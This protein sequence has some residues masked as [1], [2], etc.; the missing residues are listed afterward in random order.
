MVVLMDLE[1]KEKGDFC[2][3][4]SA[5]RMAQTSKGDKSISILQNL[6]SSIPNSCIYREEEFIWSK[7]ASGFYGDIFKVMIETRA[8]TVEYGCLFVVCELCMF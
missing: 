7:L 2:G 6:P 3:D 4:L 1:T 8:E 5:S